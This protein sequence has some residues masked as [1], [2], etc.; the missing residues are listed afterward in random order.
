MVSIA[1]IAWVRAC[2]SLLFQI[3]RPAAAHV[4]LPTP[5]LIGRRCGACELAQANTAEPIAT[6]LWPVAW[7]SKL[8]ERA[9]LAH[10]F[11]EHRAISSDAI[12]EGA[13]GCAGGIGS[14][15]RPG[16]LG[17]LLC[18]SCPQNYL[19][20]QYA[21]AYF[22]KGYLPTGIA[23]DLWGD[24]AVL[25]ASS[26]PKCGTSDRRAAVKREGGRPFV[27]GRRA[28]GHGFIL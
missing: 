27:Y 11:P 14:R 6:V 28:G 16:R 5:G 21:S 7:C 8:L 10:F 13:Y 17:A 20:R 2:N 3:Q 19:H 9:F 26:T 4:L 22:G 25:V 15:N 1:H 24:T 18:S 23:A 12:G